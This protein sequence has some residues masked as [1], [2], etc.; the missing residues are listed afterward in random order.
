MGKRLEISKVVM[1]HPV[2][3]MNINGKAVVLTRTSKRYIQDIHICLLQTVGSLTFVFCFLQIAKKYFFSNEKLLFHI[4]TAF[5]SCFQMCTSPIAAD[6]TNEKECLF[7]LWFEM[8][9]NGSTSTHTYA[10][11]TC[12]QPAGF[13]VKAISPLIFSPVQYLWKQYNAGS[14]GR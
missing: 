14:Q 7:Y 13:R 4:F 8:S 9:G 12:T 10:T 11:H 3:D 6:S 2:R 5:F 1:I